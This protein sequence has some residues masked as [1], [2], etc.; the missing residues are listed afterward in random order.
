D[1]V[2]LRQTRRL[3]YEHLGDFRDGPPA[4]HQS[5]QP[6]HIVVYLNALRE[7][8]QAF[9]AQHGRAPLIP[10]E[11][12]PLNELGAREVARHDLPKLARA[13]RRSRTR[14]V[15]GAT[16]FSGRCH[17]ADMAAEAPGRAVTAYIE[18]GRAK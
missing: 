13:G 14:P 10:A 1:Y 6:S 16:G 4:V 17:I 18:M 8:R 7:P 11:P 5:D 15:R 12:L 3:P 2:V 9:M